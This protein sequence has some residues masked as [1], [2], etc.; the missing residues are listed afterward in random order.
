MGLHDRASFGAVDPNA[1]IAALGL[2]VST[3]ST[4]FTML[5]WLLARDERRAAAERAALEAV[6]GANLMM[7]VRWRRSFLVARRFSLLIVTVALIVV[8]LFV[9]YL[10][11]YMPA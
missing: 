5:A 6:A 4:V 10:A 11:I 9:G 2:V 1:V 8:T 7:L 3:V